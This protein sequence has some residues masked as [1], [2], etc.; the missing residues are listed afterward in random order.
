M[1]GSVT[2]GNDHLSSNL[3]THVKLLIVSIKLSYKKVAQSSPL[4]V[5]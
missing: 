4:T 5:A 3:K 1:K 2:V